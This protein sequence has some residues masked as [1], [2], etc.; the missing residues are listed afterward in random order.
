MSNNSRK[1]SEH[2]SGKSSENVSKVL[3]NQSKEL[4]L[5]PENLSLKVEIPTSQTKKLV[6][7]P[8]GF[9]KLT[10]HYIL[11]VIH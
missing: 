7:R 3:Q 1:K 2:V 9:K 10:L 5:D 4:V 8:K 6:S 11:I